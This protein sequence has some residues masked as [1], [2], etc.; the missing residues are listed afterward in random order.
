MSSASAAVRK[1]DWVS[2]GSKL[3]PETAAGI[4]AF[5]SRHAAL[6]KQVADLKEQL[7]PI[8][9]ENYENILKNISVV[10]SAKQAISTF[11]A[12]SYP[13]E[14]QLKSIEAS[15]V[16]AV[17]AAKKT[18]TS[19]SGDLK[20]MKELLKHIETARPIDQLTVEDVAKA[21]PSLDATVEKMAKRGQWSVPGYYE[22][23]GEFKIGF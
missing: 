19:I 15:R 18:E 14:E 5:R 1:I 12:A 10:S 20:E 23:F 11:K 13:L 2:V 7:K 22:K 4:S 16:K 6:Q 3:K 9:F 17:A 21:Y 8:S